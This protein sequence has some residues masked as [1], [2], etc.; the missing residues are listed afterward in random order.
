MPC[1]W[2]EQGVLIKELIRTRT[3]NNRI[4][5]LEN[6]TD[7]FGV[8]FSFIQ[9]GVDRIKSYFNK[10]DCYIGCLITW[11][12]QIVYRKSMFL[13]WLF[14][15]QA[16]GSTMVSYFWWWSWIWT[17]GR[18]R[19]S[20]L[21]QTTLNMWIMI[22][23]CAYSDKGTVVSFHQI[24]VQ[25]ITCS[26][27]KAYLCKWN[28]HSVT[29]ADLNAWGYLVVILIL[30]IRSSFWML[31]KSRRGQLVY[32]ISMALCFMILHLVAVVDLAHASANNVFNSGIC[33]YCTIS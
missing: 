2:L 20:T 28:C 22:Q 8:V 4:G 13:L 33:K 32:S 18:I 24:L 14:F 12:L 16:N 30:N 31:M 25:M 6:E 26:Q 1:P 29:T 23:V 9:I 19:Y 21:L 17:C 3:Y 11:K 27:F 7:W 10:P 15:F 5:G